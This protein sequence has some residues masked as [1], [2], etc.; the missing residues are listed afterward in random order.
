MVNDRVRRE[1]ENMVRI[2]WE[3]TARADKIQEFEK[4]YA[5]SGPWTVL[6]CKNSGYHGSVLLRD[7]EQPRHYLTM[8][9]WDNAATVRAM[10]ERF[11]AEYEELDR[12]GEAFHGKRTPPGRFR[13][14]PLC[15]KT[16]AEQND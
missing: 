14:G 2:V 9:R 16:D 10:R 11:A 15:V 1:T 7:M 8:D 13:R 6:F 3:F 4:F 5:D 12:A